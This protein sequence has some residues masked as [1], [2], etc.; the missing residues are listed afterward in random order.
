M[1]NK[2]IVVHLSSSSGQTDLS[3]RLYAGA[4]IINTGGDTLTESGTSGQFSCVV[5]E[6]VTAGWHRVDVYDDTE[7]AYEGGWVYLPGDTEGTY[8]VDDP[9]AG[10]ESA[11]DVYAYFTDGTRANA[12]KATGFA[13]AGD[14][15]TLSSGE[16]DTLAAV[17]DA[18]LLNAGDA[19]DLIASIV[20]R[21]GN[22]NVDQSAFV[23]AVK[24]AL[25]DAGS[26]ANK[27]AVDSSGRVTI[28]TNGD[29]SGYALTATTGLDRKSVV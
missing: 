21:I 25:F 12:F 18:T 13:V 27:L 23:A 26:A 14:A 20:T 6:A 2:T 1:A 29:K 3:L 24:A 15:M 22:T 28:G 9:A 8:L 4:T 17:I 19:T 5:T 7:L 10:G 16:R 11:A